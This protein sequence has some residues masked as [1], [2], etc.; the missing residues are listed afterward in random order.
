M[1]LTKYGLDWQENVCIWEY[2]KFIAFGDS[3]VKKVIH[4]FQ[5]PKQKVYCYD[6][7]H[8][9]RKVLIVCGDMCRTFVDTRNVCPSQRKGVK[10][11]NM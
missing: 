9:T 4:I 10:C 8:E 6:G 7:H 11:D 5:Q 2:S 1:K 3:F